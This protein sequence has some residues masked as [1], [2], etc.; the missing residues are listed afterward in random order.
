MTEKQ[1]QAIKTINLLRWDNVIT[2]DDY[3]LLLEFIIGQAVCPTIDTTP[4][5]WTRLT[6]NPQPLDPIYGK[7]GPTCKVEE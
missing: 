4:Y 1:K 7:F 2:E 3:F 6:E 5:P